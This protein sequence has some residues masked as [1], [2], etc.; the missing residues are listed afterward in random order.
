MRRM[1]TF[2]LTV[3]CLGLLIFSPP[4]WGYPS[5]VTNMS[6]N[7]GLV[8]G[9]QSSV[10]IQCTASGADSLT[11]YALDIGCLDPV[12]LVRVGTSDDWVASDVRLTPPAAGIRSIT[13]IASGNDGD[14]AGM[15]AVNVR[16]GCLT[17]GG[18][19]RQDQASTVTV[20]Y[21]QPDGVSGTVT[22]VSTNLS[23]IGGP[24]ESVTLTET[25]PGHWESGSVS[26]TPPTSGPLIIPYFLT[27]S[28]RSSG[29]VATM[30]TGITVV[31]VAS[32]GLD[33]QVPG[34]HDA[35]ENPQSI[36]AHRVVQGESCP[37]TI[38]CT[39]ASIGSSPSADLSALGGSGAQ[40]EGWTL[41]GGTWTWSGSVTAQTAGPAT[42]S[43]AGSSGSV[44]QTVGVMDSRVLRANWMF[45]NICD[46]RVSTAV[47]GLAKFRDAGGVRGQHDVAGKQRPR[48]RLGGGR[49]CQAG[50]TGS[51]AT[52]VAAGGRRSGPAGFPGRTDGLARELL[53]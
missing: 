46:D 53:V 27:W 18:D 24:E 52:A 21:D 31:E 26:V 22:A 35:H 47:T 16:S 14:S 4:V 51:G 9:V 5:P 6:V 28:G 48:G 11:V 40:T 36:E 44:Q 30:P 49:T 25:S 10:T 29:D 20:T 32:S 2:A 34:M 23:R 38:Q 12:P 43:V 41:A 8:V 45:L 17:I 39:Q 3:G 42:I 1:A 19:L 7:N 13:F 50:G 37:I 15:L 33:L